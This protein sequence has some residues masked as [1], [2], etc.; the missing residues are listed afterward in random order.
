M[1]GAS[2]TAAPG[3][4]QPAV[5]AAEQAAGRAGGAQEGRAP[6]QGLLSRA[7]CA[8]ITS[9]ERVTAAR[10][11]FLLAGLTIEPA[12]RRRQAPGTA[13]QAAGTKA[14]KGAGAGSTGGAQGTGRSPRGATGSAPPRGHA[15]Y[16]TTPTCGHAHL[17]PRPLPPAHSSPAPPYRWPRPLFARPFTPRPKATPTP[18]ATPTPGHA[19]LPALYKARRGALP[20]LG[21]LP[22]PCTHLRCWQRGSGGCPGVSP[23]SRWW[24]LGAGWGLNCSQG[25]RCWG[26]RG[27][28]CPEALWGLEVLW[29]PAGLCWARLV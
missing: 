10:G 14:P 3:S 21:A 13:S 9:P 22:S 4:Q 19:H 5:P 29:G 27:L 26:G 15:H 24:S 2:S 25:P 28:R 6:A 20:A 18:L 11:R 16:E 7:V 23:R 17:W 8:G 12:R 1:L